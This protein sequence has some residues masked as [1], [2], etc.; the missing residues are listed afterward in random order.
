LKYNKNDFF[1]KISLQTHELSLNQKYY[2]KPE[3]VISGVESF[4]KLYHAKIKKNQNLKPP[5][6]MEIFSSYTFS[7]HKVYGG[8]F[9]KWEPVIFSMSDSSLVNSKNS[10][11][12]FYGITASYPLFDFLKT[13]FKYDIKHSPFRKNHFSPEFELISELSFR[14]HIIGE[15]DGHIF[16][17]HR[18]AMNYFSQYYSRYLDTFWV[19]ENETQKMLNFLEIEGNFKLKSAIFKLKVANILGNFSS[20]IIG[21]KPIGRYISFGVDWN[22][23]D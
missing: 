1:A 6:S 23:N 15:L 5:K 19:A 21:Y 14:S 4:F 9:Q 2:E 18:F 22:F 12:L 11:N 13:E 8:F 16:L 17:R 20:Q 7:K 3:S 10:Q